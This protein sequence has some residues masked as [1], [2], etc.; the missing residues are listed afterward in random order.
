MEER[1]LK[2]YAKANHFSHT[3]NADFATASEKEL[4]K[5]R[6]IF[7]EAKEKYKILSTQMIDKAGILVCLKGIM[8][9]K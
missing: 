8:I 9:S 3:K 6:L 5:I 1:N 4:E 2:R 7:Q